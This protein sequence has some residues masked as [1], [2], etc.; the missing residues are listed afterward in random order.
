MC[1]LAPPAMG[2]LATPAT[3]SESVFAM[4]FDMSR[5]G[6]E[7]SLKAK[8]QMLRG[9]LATLESSAGQTGQTDKAAVGKLRQQL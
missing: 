4:P 7:D 8:M 1:E 5:N 2:A 6:I 9:H 3:L